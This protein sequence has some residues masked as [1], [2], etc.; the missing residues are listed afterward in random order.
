MTKDSAYVDKI[1]VNYKAVIAGKDVGVGRVNLLNGKNTVVFAPGSRYT[2]EIKGGK[3]L[4]QT[5]PIKKT[6]TF[7]KSAITLSRYFDVGMTGTEAMWCGG[8]QQFHFKLKPAA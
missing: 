3:S 4:T 2:T 8:T 7:N 5:Y 6:V 1:S